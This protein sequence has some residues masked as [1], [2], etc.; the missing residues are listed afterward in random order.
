MT[1]YAP[2]SAPGGDPTNVT[3]RRIGAFVIDLVLLTII[4]LA[5]MIPKFQ[6]MAI[7]RPAFG[8]TCQEMQDR[9][10][11]SD[12]DGSFCFQNGDEIRYIPSGK[13]GE[14]AGTFYL[15]LFGAELLNWV[16]LQ[17]LTGA[18]IGK[19][20]CG[21]RVVRGS[22]G[23]TANIGWAALRTLLLQIDLMCCGILG[24]V[25]MA[26]TKGHRR[27]GDMASG[28]FV[29]KA[30]DVGR[31]VMVPG[32][33]AGYGGYGGPGYTP[34]NYGAPAGWD[35]GSP[36]AQPT[37]GTPPAQ[38]GAPGGAGGWA[39]PAS[40]QPG[41]FG[42]PLPPADP[43]QPAAPSAVPGADSPTWD[44]A[45]NAYIQYDRELSA[46]M[47]WDDASNQWKPISQ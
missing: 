10:L 41:S 8:R 29:V 3:G 12:I 47:Q 32:L 23:K 16:I 15:V 22:T 6:D 19:F 7:T 9:S 20:V 14:F 28:T 38:P 43:T 46:W 44:P 1:T 5:V 39:T 42:A 30:S 17:G 31:P 21:V 2:Y 26:S 25:L 18:S 27:L 11:E 24:I 36:S 35:V 34:P 4:V 13:T 37:W 45:R 33:T 40:G